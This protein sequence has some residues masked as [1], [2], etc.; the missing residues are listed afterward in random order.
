[1]D[2]ARAKN[3]LI[4]IFVLLNLFLLTMITNLFNSDNI[5][6]ETIDSTY[7][8]LEDRGIVV[9][10]D[11]PIYNKQIGTLI[12][13][14]TMFDKD[15]IIKGFFGDEQYIEDDLGTNIMAVSGNKE[16][17]IGKV[18]TFVY[19]NSD[20]K[21]DI[22]L[23]D[24]KAVQSYLVSLFKRLNVVFEKFHLDR[25]EELPNG[26]KSYIFRQKKDGFW[27]YSNYIDITI[28]K[29]GICYLKYN[30]RNVNEFT[31]GQKI[32]PAYQ[33]LIKNLIYDKG[34]VVEKIDVGFGEQFMGKETKVLD[35]LP[36]WRIA[37]QNGTKIEE[38]YY[39][40]Y[41]GEEVKLNVK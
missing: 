20:P 41:N 25:V 1:M 34:A 10:C 40:V 11:I 33:V 15:L 5:S 3:I 38:R 29:S 18:N 16:L 37:L 6:S 30:N 14:D 12:S 4:F 26:Q 39:K 22:Y 31:K 35:D 19:K 2:W 7:K 24:E 9:N 36:V 13:S 21:D 32:M 8:V 27:L 28:S 17:L 23:N